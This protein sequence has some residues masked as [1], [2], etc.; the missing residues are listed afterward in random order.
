MNKKL[1]VV[2]LFSGAGG[3]DLGFKQAGF[4]LIWA[5]DF[6]K[7]AV[8]TYKENIG[9]ECVLGDIT[10][11]PSSEIPNADVMIGGFPC[12]GFSMANTKRHELDERNSLYLEYVRILK[13]KQPK[14]F[15]AENVK[16]ILSL[17]KG[18]IIKAIIQDFSDAGYSVEYKLLNAADYGVPQTRQRVIIVGIRKDLDIQF[19]FP[20]QT[21]SKN[22]NDGLKRW[23]SIKEAISHLPDPDGENADS[24][25]NN[26]YSQYKIIMNGYLGKRPINENIPAPTVTGRGDAKGG[27]VILPH[28][29]GHRRM[30]VRELATIQSFPVDFQF[31]GNKTNCYRQIANAVPVGLSKAIA[32]SILKSFNV[33]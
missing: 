22:G 4:N 18:E 31:Q 3:L 14:V 26:E 1:T 25:P 19:E 12:Q 17:G 9:K 6:D 30:T 5:N 11:I 8:E 33:L 29:N 15:V 2:S 10:K 23:V 20:K 16:G 13:A 7:D 28:P 27:V 24:V 32:G 21:H